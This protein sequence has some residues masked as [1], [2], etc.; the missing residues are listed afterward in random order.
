MS[1][2]INSCKEKISLQEECLNM[3]AEKVEA[4]RGHGIAP[5]GLSAALF[6]GPFEEEEEGIG[7]ASLSDVVKVKGE[8]LATPTLNT[9]HK[10]TKCITN[11]PPH[12]VPRGRC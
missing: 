5:A 3:V 9:E 2:L 7:I 1:N 8:D 10:P 12:P 6:V 4:C 11:V